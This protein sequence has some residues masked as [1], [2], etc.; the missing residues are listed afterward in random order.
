MPRRG[1]R[2]SYRGDAGPQAAGALV[3]RNSRVGEA[4]EQR[5]SPICRCMRQGGRDK[6]KN[7]GPGHHA[8][9]CREWQLRRKQDEEKCLF[10]LL[11]AANQGG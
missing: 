11:A 2:G 10:L 1:T 8:R 7:K 4:A 5:P 3:L 9:A 6:K